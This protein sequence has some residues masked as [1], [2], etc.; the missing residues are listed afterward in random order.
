MIDEE[1]SDDEI[2]RLGQ[3]RLMQRREAIRVERHAELRGRV[4]RSERLSGLNSLFGIAAAFGRGFLNA[5]DNAPLPP[6]PLYQHAPP[7]PNARFWAIPKKYRWARLD[8]P[9]V[10]PDWGRRVPLVSEAHRERAA[11]WANGL[12]NG[13]KLNLLIACE[14][15]GKSQTGTGKTSLAAAVARFVSERTGLPITWVHAADLRGDREDKGAAVAA[16]QRLLSAPLSVLDGLGKELGGAQDV[17]GWQPARIAPIIDYSIKMYERAE[18]IRI[19]TRDLP[20]RTMIETHGAD[21]VR[22]FG[23]IDPATNR[24]E[25]ATIIML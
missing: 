17:R 8:R 21:F 24:E 18:G 9:I 14:H 20:E 11:L 23:W 16:W 1:L 25:N 15:D 10:P 13:P 12:G 22:R 2:L 7:D 3:E 19:V 6:R 5:E 4:G